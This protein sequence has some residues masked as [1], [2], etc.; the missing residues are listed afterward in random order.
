M[1][2]AE[3]ITQ[4]IGH[5]P[6]VRL[7]KV[8][9]GAVAD[10]VAKTKTGYGAS[11]ANYMAELLTERLTGNPATS[12]MNDAMRWGTEQEPNARAAYEFH[13]ERDVMQVGF[14][15]H[16]S[17]PM[18]GASP[19]GYVLDDGLVEF[20]CPNTATHLDTLLGEPVAD[21]YVKQM[22]WQMACADRAWCD[23]VSFDP[24]LPPAMQLF[25]KRIERDDKIIQA[26]EG[27][28]CAFLA[29]LD[30]KERLLRDQYEVKAAA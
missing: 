19:D 9:D 22:Q 3:N 26:I 23:W 7:R 18:C 2:I 21:K 27:E 25:V 24:R 6:L 11:R 13:C 4:L 12:F 28:V 10:V 5:T 29:E 17:I 1:T 15:H 20:K 30:A 16:P 8:T 14:V